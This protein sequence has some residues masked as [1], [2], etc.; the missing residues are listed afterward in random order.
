M[1]KIGILGA[2]DIAYNKFIPAIKKTDDAECVGIASKSAKKLQRFVDD[3]GIKVYDSYEA[4][5]ADPDINCVYIPLPPMYHYEW[6]KKALLAGKHTFLE[7]PSA[8]DYEKAHELVTL[9][10]SKGLVLQENYMYLFHSQMDEVKKIISSGKLGKIRLLRASFGFPRRPAGDFRYIKELGGGTMMDNGGYTIRIVSELLGDVSLVGASLDCNDESGVDIFGAASFV[11]EEGTIAQ[12]AFGMDCQYQCSLELWGSLGRLTTNRIFT[13]PE[14]FEPVIL[15]ETA[16]GKEE[17]KLSGDD[18]FVKAIQ[19]F[20]KATM[21]KDYATAYADN[22][23]RQAKL[24]D[25]VIKR[26]MK[27]K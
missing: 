17:I 24:V 2:A 14:G 8:T 19:A 27:K 10:K 18:H 26:G 23:D 11:N 6:A 20:S 3:F 7:K 4:I 16:T 5:L 25:E 22:L 13:A 15:L 1:L 21:D 9:A 12:V